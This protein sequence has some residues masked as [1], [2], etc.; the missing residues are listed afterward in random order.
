[1]A[2]RETTELAEQPKAGALANIYDYGS[3]AGSGF[4]NQ[5]SADVKLPFITVLQ[6]LS[7]QT[8]KN[9]PEFIQGAE[10][11]ILI[12]TVTLE[13]MPDGVDFVPATTEHV[14]VEWVPRNS[15]G[16]F[17]GKHA[18]NSDI[19]AQA[20]A[21]SKEFGKLKTANGNDLIETFYV[22]G[23]AISN[24]MPIPAVVA[25]SSTKIKVYKRWMT[26]VRTFQIDVN[27]RR[28]VPP[29][30]AHLAR[31]GTVPETNKRGDDYFNFSVEPSNGDIASSLL[32]PT[33]ERFQAARSLREMVTRGAVQTSEES[34]AATGGADAADVPF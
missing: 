20:R 34:V 23:I 18:P 19:V 25:F 2:K 14:F 31:I 26:R 11:G 24:G 1:M 12:N 5:T 30:F 9:K 17:V 10:P 33:D 6:D 13:L 21:E 16:G 8:K 4:E 15:G 29:L 22:Y 27:G 32:P 3:E 28:Q 7:P